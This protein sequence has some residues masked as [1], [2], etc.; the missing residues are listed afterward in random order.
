[1][2]AAAID[3]WR[4]G[5]FPEQ[6]IRRYF[7]LR[8]GLRAQTAEIVPVPAGTSPCRVELPGEFNWSAIDENTAPQLAITRAYDVKLEDC[9]PHLF[10][11]RILRAA[12]FAEGNT[13]LVDERCL[14]EVP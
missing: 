1:M 2:K 12:Y 13:I 7:V 10:D 9:Y 11:S 6:D 5:K 14:S 4:L 3:W 8:T